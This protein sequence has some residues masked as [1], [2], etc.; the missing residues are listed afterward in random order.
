MSARRRGTRSRTV[1]L[2]RNSLESRGGVTPTLPGSPRRSGDEVRE[3]T[4]ELFGRQTAPQQCV[5]VVVV[6]DEGNDVGIR[7]FRQF[8]AQARDHR[9]QDLVVAADGR[10]P[11]RC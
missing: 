11:S 9:E 7:S 4:L 2:T 6:G 10:F 1:W 8:L 5:G 3:M